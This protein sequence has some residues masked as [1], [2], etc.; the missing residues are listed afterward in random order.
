MKRSL[1][2][3]LSVNTLQLVVNQFFALVVFYVLS[4]HLDK[5]N[6]GQ[7]N[8]V[9]AI[10]LAAFSI[11]SLGIDQLVVKKVAAD[12]SPSAVLSLYCYHVFFTGLVFYGTLFSIHYLFP[13]FFKSYNV[14]IMIGIGKLL[15]YFSTP[16][17]QVANGLERFRLLAFISVISNVVR[18]LALIYFAWKSEL[19]L[20]IVILIFISG[21]VVEFL[22]SILLFSSVTRISPSLRF[23][24]AA[25]I[26]LIKIAL[27][28]AGVVIITSAL[29]RFDWIFI[30]IVSSAS[31]LAEYSFAY[32]VYEVSTLPLL[33][34]APLLIP[35]F[36][37][38]FKDGSFSIPH[39]QLMIRVE[40]MV[41]GLTILLLNII[42]TPLIDHLTAGKY[43]A[44]NQHTI[45][46][47]SLSI[48]FIYSNN[49]LWT[50][51][52]AQGRLKMILHS[53]ILAVCINVVLD[54]VLIPV[55][56]NE[57]AAIG[58]MVSLSC[59][60]LFF[61]SKNQLK[62]LNNAFFALPIC[63]VCAVFAVFAGSHFFEGLTIQIPIATG[64]FILLILLT[65]Q[66]KPKEFWGLFNISRQ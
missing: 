55:M 31:K 15:M 47:L 50:M 19:G 10:L 40:M 34:I 63:V 52:F 23:N 49:F 42:W 4:T 54:I 66:I 53:F 44:V 37:K 38:M 56:H 64:T 6:F 25:Y 13:D 20:H 32:K 3:N 11:L 1:I 46:I 22:L 48:P 43:G 18:G 33:A 7:I 62:E 14:L 27:P 2:K 16:F 60:T 58:V 28:Q 24:K 35:H 39:S 51:Y 9:L 30:G 59:Q 17:K 65:G 57:G 61:I 41:A 45:F 5:N 26:N 29:A 36:T 21:D 12:D 8:L